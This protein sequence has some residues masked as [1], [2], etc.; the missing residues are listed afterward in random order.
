MGCGVE[1]FLTVGMR[2]N[3]AP[4]GR[5]FF[6]GII[7]QLH[8]FPSS[9]TLS[10]VQSQLTAGAASTPMQ[11][12]LS[13]AATFSGA[14]G[15]RFT[16]PSLAQF[17]VFGNVTMYFAFEQQAGSSGYIFAK[18]NPTGQLRYLALYSRSAAS[19]AVWLYYVTR[20]TR[21]RIVFNH[22]VSDGIMHT[23]EL[24]LTDSTAQLR[25]DGV[26]DR[27]SLEGPVEDCGALSATC[28]LAV[29]DRPPADFRFEGNISI[30]AVAS[31]VSGR[32]CI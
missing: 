19:Q 15:L 21:H 4:A 31:T 23:A 28:I 11:A 13:S 8:L 30:L 16:D 9:A 22:A 25:I 3:T 1:C 14:S 5:F 26:A 29:G 12:V 27:Q 24:T 10:S 2:S 18:A 7:T 17:G 6:N 32:V 20:G